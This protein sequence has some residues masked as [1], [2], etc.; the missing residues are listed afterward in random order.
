MKQ[1]WMLKTKFLIPFP[2]ADALPRPHLIGWLEAQSDRR[3][4]LISAPAGYGKTTLLID[5]LKGSKHPSAWFQIDEADSDPAVFVSNLIEAIRSIPRSLY[6]SAAQAAHSLLHNSDSNLDPR[7]VLSVL[8]NDLIEKTPPPFLIAFEDYHF[9]TNPAVHQLVDFFIDHAP[10][11]VQLII[12]S[13]SDPM[14]A[15]GR[16]R[17]RGQLAELRA[18]DLRFRDDEVAAWITRDVPDLPNESLTLLS[19]KTEGW[20][21]ALQIV[22]TSLLGKDQ[23]AARETISGLSGSHRHIF[24]YLADEVFQRQSND[25]QEFLLRTAILSQLDASICN[26]MADIHNGQAM[27]EE[28]ETQNLFLIS[29][30]PQRRWYRYHFLFQDFLLNKLAGE[31]P[32]RKNALVRRAAQ[33]YEEHGEYEAAFQH[34]ATVQDYESAARAIEAVAEDYIERGRV[35]IAQRSLSLIPADIQRSRPNLLIQQG[36]AHRRMG[37]AGLAIAAYEEARA[38]FSAQKDSSGLSRALTHLAE[39]HRAQGNYPQAEGLGVQALEAASENDHAARAEALMALAKSTGFLTGM[40]R[41]RALAEQAVDESRLASDQISKLS[42]ASFLQALGQICWWHGDPH[43]SAR[44]C[45]EALSLA[46][47]PLSP[48]AAQ[49]HIL[50]V[51][52]NL[53]WR[54]LQTALYHAEEGLRIAQILHL[55][56]LIPAAYT[57][58][59]NTLTRIGETARAENALRES[60]DLA[61]R[62][63]MA[64]YEQLM[65]TGYLAYNLYGQ[66]RVDESRQ[67]AE[68]ALWTHAGSH[69][70][71]EA[72][73]CRSVLADIALECGDLQRAKNLFAELV[74]IGN[75]R[76]F[77]IP[78]AMVHFG[79]AYIDLTANKTKRGMDHARRALELIE[80]TK[81]FQL[82][83]DQGDR[84]VIVCRALIEAGAQSPFIDRVLEN[85]PTKKRKTARITIADSSAIEVRTLGRFAVSIRGEEIT[86]E[87]WVSTKARDLLAYFITFRGEHIP[88]D[89]AFD[90]IWS[91]KPG[92]G[93]T[94]FHTALSRLRS[95][96]RTDEKSPRLILVEAGEYRIDSARF[97]ID[98]DEFDSALAKARAI[99]NHETKSAL[100]EQAL[101]LYGGEYLQ[102]FY[103]DWLM[104]ERQRAAQTYIGALEALADIHHT[105]RRYTHALELLQRALRIDPLQE[106]LHCQAMRVYASLGD[107]AGLMRQYQDLKEILLQEIGFEPLPATVRLYER[108]LSTLGV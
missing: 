99:E 55:N 104:P 40:D 73:V 31:N 20:A 63:G 74:E 70:T 10:A 56:E 8:I 94:A 12:S 39:I 78:L 32:P 30:D 80:P 11:G 7:R 102:N 91:E 95:A 37:Q 9:I 92:R 79:L 4:I 105:G 26:A 5:F 45:K 23:T 97:K 49:C 108:L 81:A 58:L 107:R 85:L 103:Y 84:S 96:L 15:L 101:Q 27:L 14:L 52:P 13:R 65:A 43:A 66:G 82:F 29:L 98:I 17:A 69:D 71:Y 35:E 28:L 19:E 106:D 57:A 59:G 2:G 22:R 33:Y 6:A 18:A 53:Y 36:N 25:R 90:S 34:Y 21:A 51:T 64:S 75:R 54:E 86:Q 93:L 1:S 68:G 62:L 41:G 61:R 3:M 77:K 42:Q 88:A 46:P 100:Y 16:L 72:Y 67:L 87:R 48:M 60:V 50:L 47:D 89:R 44:Y 24:D 38:A 76:Q 83:V